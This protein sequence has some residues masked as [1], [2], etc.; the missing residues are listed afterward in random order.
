MAA[1]G[2]ALVAVGAF[3][4]IH[5]AWIVPIWPRL[6][7]GLPFALTGALVLAWCYSRFLMGERLPR[8]AGLGGLVFGAGAWVALIPATGV[9]TVLR[10]TG[11]HQGHPTWSTGA[12][13][14]MAA[15][16]GFCIGRA[17]RLGAS[18]ILATMAAAFVLLS[19]QAGPI[20]VV[21]GWRPIG[22]FLL[23]APLYA[24]CGLVQALQTAWLI[25]QPRSQ[26][27]PTAP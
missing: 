13:L 11:F 1:V 8:P 27:R 12:E 23:L 26:P 9:A 4:L 18:G 3:G 21:N 22:L 20:P 5:A 7:G 17:A 15:L 10:L 24:V 19:V 6:L 16:T 2:T 25:D 14:G